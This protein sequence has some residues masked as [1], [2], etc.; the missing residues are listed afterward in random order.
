MP[1]EIKPTALQKVASQHTRN[2]SPL[3]AQRCT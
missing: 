3:Q 1:N 2:P